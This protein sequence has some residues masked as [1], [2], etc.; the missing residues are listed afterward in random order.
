MK[1]QVWVVWF[2]M[3]SSL[4]IIQFILGKGLPSMSGGGSVSILLVAPL[5]LILGSMAVRFLVVP[6]LKLKMQFF[7]FMT[8]GMSM[9]EMAHF[10]GIFI[11]GTDKPDMVVIFPM[12]LLAMLTY[13][14][15]YFP[16][17]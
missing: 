14:P 3:T 8:G 6:K 1:K 16:E 4:V 9:A 13:A 2:A 10:V 11:I 17:D 12:A 15:V 5:V 7:V